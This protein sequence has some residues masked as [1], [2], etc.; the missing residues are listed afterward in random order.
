MPNPCSALLGWLPNQMASQMDPHLE[1]RVEL[2]LYC[3]RNK[4]PVMKVRT[5]RRIRVMVNVS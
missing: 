3:G 5:E 2:V 4:L 1:G